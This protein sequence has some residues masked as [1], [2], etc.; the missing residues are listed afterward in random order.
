MPLRL[1]VFSKLSVGN[2]CSFFSV[3]VYQLDLMFFTI[4]P[5]GGGS[6][7]DEETYLSF[8]KDIYDDL[9]ID[10]EENQDL[11][12]FFKDNAPSND[13]LVASRAVAFKAACNY[14]SDDKG[15]NIKLLKCIN[16]VIHGYETTCLT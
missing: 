4:R 6:C 9:S 1:L 15:E 7:N 3:V 13:Y 14:L 2:I 12:D 5:K 10:R 8:Y 11:I 16:V